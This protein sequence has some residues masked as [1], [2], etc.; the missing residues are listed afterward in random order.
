MLE[1]IKN[2]IDIYGKTHCYVEIKGR[3]L[4]G[5]SSYAIHRKHKEVGK[6]IKSVTEAR[7]AVDYKF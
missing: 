5:L 1:Y 4:E 7:T 3:S 2:R 6:F